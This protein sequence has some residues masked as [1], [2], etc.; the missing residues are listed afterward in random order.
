MA[1]KNEPFYHYFKNNYALNSNYWALFARSS[2]TT[3]GNPCTNMH[4]ESFHNILKRVYNHG[5]RKKQRV[6]NLLVTLSTYLRD[7]IYDH[8]ITQIRGGKTTKRTNHMNK[9]HE[10][11]KSVKHESIIK[12]TENENCWSVTSSK[13]ESESYSIFKTVDSCECA[14]PLMCKECLMCTHYKC[15]CDDSLSNRALLCKHIHAVG[16]FFPPNKQKQLEIPEDHTFSNASC[17]QVPKSNATLSSES[18]PIAG[19]IISTKL[20]GIASQTDGRALN[21]LITKIMLKHIKRLETLV[22]F[23]DTDLNLKLNLKLLRNAKRKMEKQ[24]RSIFPTNKKKKRKLLQAS[25]K[26]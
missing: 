17:Y 25:Q 20:K 11:G 19:D 23:P 2:L 12:K 18:R 16:I 13:D 9:L 15:T 21:P 4:L 10:E 3:D 5:K 22:K 7:K 8:Q 6:D 1:T 14:S 26:K 24:P